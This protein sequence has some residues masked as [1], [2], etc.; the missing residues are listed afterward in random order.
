MQH[1]HA[2]GREVDFDTANLPLPTFGKLA[3]HQ[4]AGAQ[5]QQQDPYALQRTA[6][7]LPARRHAHQPAAEHGAGNDHVAEPVGRQAQAKDLRDVALADPEPRIQPVAHGNAADPGAQVQVE[8]VADDPHG[9]N[10]LP[11]QV[12]ADVGAA[13]QVEAGVHQKTHQGQPRGNDQCAHLE[14]GQGI[15]HFVPFDALGEHR[16][17]HDQHQEKQHRQ[18]S[19][20]AAPVRLFGAFGVSFRVGLSAVHG[21]HSRLEG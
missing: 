19:F 9:Q 2:Q 21:Q 8:G 20:P 14:I 15:E 5:Q 13:D 7:E 17:Q 16:E 18:R 4:V 3:R 6:A 12:L 11:G 10:L 1:R